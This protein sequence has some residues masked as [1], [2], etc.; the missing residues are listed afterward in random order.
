MTV[1]AAFTFNSWSF[2]DTLDL[3]PTGCTQQ[4]DVT[5]IL[6]MSGS[7]DTVYNS[8]INLIKHVIYGLPVR[9]DRARVALV[10][11]SD[12]A[13]V[14]FYLNTYRSKQE[15]LNALSFRSAGGKTNTQE[16]IRKAYNDVY[17][18]GR[19]DRAGVKNIAIVVSDGNS[20]INSDNTATEARVARQR[21]IEVYVA[22]VSDSVNMGE[23]NDIANDPDSTHVV[24]IRG[25]N[26]VQNAA[27]Q[28]L[29]RMCG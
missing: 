1:I 7:V 19:G 21:H 24:R 20:N 25:Q 17:S 5:F 14:E 23:V 13:K 6:D 28:L 26:D 27:K 18:S 29:D 9:A 12:S 10:S 11:Y 4:M 3:L 22:A 15:I 8:S 16:A 2:V